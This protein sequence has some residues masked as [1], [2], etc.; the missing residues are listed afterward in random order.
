MK[1]SALDLSKLG[2]IIFLKKFLWRHIDKNGE[3]P[4]MVL[5]LNHDSRTSILVRERTALKHGRI[6]SIVKTIFYADSQKTTQ[7]AEEFKVE[8]KSLVIT[9]NNKLVL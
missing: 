5:N 9:H 2:C 3:T 7:K 1:R 4:P 6:K 8:G